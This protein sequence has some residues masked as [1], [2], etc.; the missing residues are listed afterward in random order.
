MW[1]EE[2]GD[3]EKICE[4]LGDDPTDICGYL[5]DLGVGLGQGFDFCQTGPISVNQMDHLVQ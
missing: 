1:D 2:D 5:S 3:L 4:L